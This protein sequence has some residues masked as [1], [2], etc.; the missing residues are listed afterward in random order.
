MKTLTDLALNHCNVG[1]LIVDETLT[2]RFC[3]DWLSTAAQKDNNEILGHNINDIFSE[4]LSNRFLRAANGALQGK[5]SVLSQKLN[6]SPLPLYITKDI[7]KP[8]RML[9]LTI[10]TPLQL[11]SGEFYCMIQIFD[12]SESVRK[13]NALQDYAHKAKQAADE[14]GEKEAKIRAILEGAKDCILLIREDG[15]IENFN[16]CAVTTFGYSMERLGELNI[17]QLVEEIATWKEDNPVPVAELLHEWRKLPEAAE[18]IGIVSDGSGIPIDFSINA[19]E[20]GDESYFVIV[21]RDITERKK[22]EQR[23]EYMAR[24]DA[25]TDLANRTLLKSKLSDAL[26]EAKNHDGLSNRA[27]DFAKVE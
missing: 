20:F 12:V 25:L 3:N 18:L 4:K 14:L 9:E 13:E 10:M 7:N 5:T 17:S 26:E 23:L 8:E 21:V 11:D 16:H 2:V 15:S 24:Y 22:S 27:G 1:I 6:K 19:M